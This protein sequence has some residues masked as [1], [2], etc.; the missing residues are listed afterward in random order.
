MHQ[1]LTTIDTGIIRS[2]KA[3][4]RQ[5]QVRRLIELL[6]ENKT[7][8]INLKEAIRYIAMAWKTITPSTI[9]NC[10]R[11]TGILQLP[12]KN[13]DHE[14]DDSIW[15][16]STLLK[17][18]EIACDGS[19]SAESFLDVDAT[20]DIGEQTTQDDIIALVSNTEMATEDSDDD[21]DSEA[22]TE[23]VPTVQQAREAARILQCYFDSTSDVESSWATSKLL[24]KLDI[25]AT[26]QNSGFFA[27]IFL[28]LV[29]VHVEVSENM[30]NFV[31]CVE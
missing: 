9:K 13:C 14:E 20:V 26:R 18:N 10:W 25:A 30:L 24:N 31:V 23:N 2:C 7:A 15:T 16:L 3:I 19:M 28:S 6:E 4:Y 12:E 11:H 17:R 21:E 22:S 27:I 29:N 1:P 5:Y 8:D